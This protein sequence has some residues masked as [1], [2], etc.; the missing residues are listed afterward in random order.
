[1]VTQVEARR[2]INSKREKRGLIPELVITNYDWH[3]E[4]DLPVGGGQGR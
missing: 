2:S 1:L 3:D 4:P